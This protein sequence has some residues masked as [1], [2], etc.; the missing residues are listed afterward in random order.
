MHT[1][2]K[3]F[4]LRQGG[5]VFVDICTFVCKYDYS[6][7]TPIFIE[8][9]GNVAHGSWKKPPVIGVIWITLREGYGYG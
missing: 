9:I 1:V 4:Y 5:C 7:T 8:F 3:H 6:K 2:W